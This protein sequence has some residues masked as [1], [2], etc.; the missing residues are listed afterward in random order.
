MS[1]SSR[2]ST[3][4]PVKLR[5]TNGMLSGVRPLTQIF[6]KSLINNASRSADAIVKVAFDPLK[7]DRIGQEKYFVLDDEFHV[8][9]MVKITNDHEFME[10]YLSQTVIDVGVAEQELMSPMSPV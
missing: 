5:M 10:M 2:L 4:A 1:N 7:H 9:D 3:N 8:R 6:S